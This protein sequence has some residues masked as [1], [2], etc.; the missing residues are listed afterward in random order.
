MG[1]IIVLSSFPGLDVDDEP[2][3]PDKLFRDINGSGQ[4][5]ARIVAQIQDQRLHLLLT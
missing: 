4:E 1:L 5:A 2:I 3:Q